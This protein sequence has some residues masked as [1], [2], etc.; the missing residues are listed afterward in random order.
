[1]VPLEKLEGLLSPRLLESLAVEMEVDAPNQVRLPGRAVFLC[2]LNTVINSPVVTLRLLEENLLY[3]FGTRTDHSSFG[4]R[5]AKLSPDYFEAIFVHL[6]RRLEAQLPKRGGRGLR[7]RRVDATTVT[8]SAKL[9]HFGLIQRPHGKARNQTA[10]RHMKAVIT[11]SEAGLPD[12]LRICRDRCESNDNHALGRSMEEAATPGD[13]WVFDRGCKDRE[14]LLALHRRDSFWLTP[15][16]QQKL[17]VLEAVWE[18]PETAEA[19][20]TRTALEEEART[21]PKDPAP[22]QMLRVE[23][24]VFENAEDA[25][26]PTWQAKW[27]TMPLLVFHL[28]RY[29]RRTGAWEP[30]VL[31]TNLPLSDDRQ[32]AGPYR[33]AEVPELYRA[34]WELEVLFKFLKQHLSYAHLTSFC[35]NGIRL[36]VWMT[37]IAALLMIWYQRESGIDR[38]WR[39][40]KF[41]LGEDTR[42]W[43]AAALAQSRHTAP[44]AVALGGA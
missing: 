22:S 38:G 23:R 4:R 29:N 44:P 25:Q 10:K 37:L 34:R 6:Y 26:H 9:L 39:S 33:F 13:L 16:C 28:E 41:W 5:F 2:L 30:F 11:L 17:R 43:T 36:L 19:A 12:L 7:V 40:V 32:G 1:M 27:A 18:G 14:R 21:H 20:A 3:L 42:T 8:A 35:E 24:A 15:H 31:L